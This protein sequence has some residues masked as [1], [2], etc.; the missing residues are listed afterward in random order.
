VRRVSRDGTIRVLSKQVFVSNT[1]HDDHV[2]LEQV[3]DGVYDLYFCFYQIGR[4]HLQENRIEDIVSR[5]PVTRRQ[6]DLARRVLPMS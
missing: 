4:Y 2:G 6:I 3:D 1:L 5:V